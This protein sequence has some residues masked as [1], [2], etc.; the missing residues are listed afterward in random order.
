[1]STKVE[2]VTGTV[3]VKSYCPAL[4][5]RE[6]VSSSGDM[7]RLFKLLSPTDKTY[8]HR[9]EISQQWQVKVKLSLSVLVTG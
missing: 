9:V 5:D 2:L 4:G 1:M 6:Q 8:R 3:V 7:C